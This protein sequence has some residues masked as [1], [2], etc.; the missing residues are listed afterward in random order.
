MGNW[1][2]QR[3][4]NATAA[5]PRTP[6]LRRTAGGRSWLLDA[7]AVMRRAENPCRRAVLWVMSHAA[8]YCFDGAGGPLNAR[9]RFALRLLPQA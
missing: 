3:S 2:A 9:S 7:N 4:G 5:S 1:A 8:G 6:G